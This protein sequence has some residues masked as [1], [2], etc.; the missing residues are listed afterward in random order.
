MPVF[1]PL[2]NGKH[3][4]VVNPIGGSRTRDGETAVRAIY[5]IGT[6]NGSKFVPDTPQ[7]KNVDL[8]W[9]QI[10]PAVTRKPN[11]Q[12][13]AIGIVDKP[14]INYVARHSY[15]N[16]L[17]QKGVATDVISESMGH[18]NLAITQAYLK[19]LDNSVLDD[20]SELLL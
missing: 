15:A 12:L 1:E 14:L 2:G 13:V 4:L 5:W 19:E 10:S 9:G 3:L 6:W 17:K 18:Q 20:T 16:C 7:H 8:I 11:G